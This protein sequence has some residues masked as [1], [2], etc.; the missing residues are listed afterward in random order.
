[1]EV[2][3]ALGCPVAAEMTSVLRLELVNRSRILALPA[4]EPTVRG[5]SGASLLV[6]DESA[7]VPDGLYY[8]VR[9]F[10][11]TSGGQ[12]VALSTPYGRR[13]WYSDAWHGTGPWQRVKIT[14]RQCSRIPPDWLLEE[15]HSLGRRV[16]S[17]EYLCE[18]ADAVGAVFL[19][20]DIEAA[21]TSNIKPLFCA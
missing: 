21:I 3:R 18:F 15:E 6:I 14:A 13:G 9:P 19:D 8:C 12:L 4:S 11:A 2:Y 7:R 20:S 16:F 10:L 5:F 1:M 17:Q